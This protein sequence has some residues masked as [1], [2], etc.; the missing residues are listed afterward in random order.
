MSGVKEWFASWRLMSWRSALVA[1]F[2]LYTLVG[3]LVVPWVAEKVI[4]N[5]AH[6]KLGREVTV[7]KI[8]CNPFTLSLTVERLNL[9]DRPGS[10]MLSFDEMYANLQASSLFRWAFTLKEVRIENPYVA[11]RRFEDGGINVLEVK[12][13]LG[14]TMDFSDEA[15]GLPRA[16]LRE[17][18][19]NDAHFDIE[20]RAREEPLLWPGGPAQ[21]VL[22]EISTI[23]DGLGTNDIAIGL[24]AGGTIRIAGSVVV[25]PFGL[26]GA[27]SIDKIIAADLWP[28]IGHKFEFGVQGGEVATDLRYRIWLGE[29]GLGL[30]VD[31]LEAQVSDLSVSAPDS[32][33]DLVQAPAIVV[34]GGSLMWPEARLEAES[35]VVEGANAAVWL[36]PD[37]T[38]VWKTLVPEETRQELID[39]WERLNEEY[40]PVAT[41]QHF[42]VN[43]ATA[44]FEDR[45]FE[46]PVRVEASDAA[47]VVTDISS[48]PGSQ[49]GLEASAALAGG[50]PA[51]AIGTMMASPLTVDAEVGVEGLDLAQFQPYVGKFVPVELRAGQMTASGKARLAPS[52]EGP[53]VTFEGTAS[54]GDLDLVET[55]TD[56]SLL[57]WGE[58]KIDGIQAALLPTSAEVAK[59]DIHDA[60]LEVIVAEDGAINVLEFFNE[61]AP[62]LEKLP[63]AHIA[64]VELHDCF[65]RYFEEN[66]TRP[67]ELSLEAVNG[68]VVGFATNATTTSELE[69]DAAISTGGAVRVTGELDPL[70]YT[71]IT[72]MQVDVRD[73]H[74]PPMSPKSA[75]LVGHPVD[76]GTASLDLDIE[77]TD[78]Q[79]VS[80]N[81]VVITNLQLGERVDGDR[82][83]DLPV[84]LGVKLLK[85]KNGQI[86]LDIPV[87]G[88]MS[89]PD[90]VMTAAFT[91]AFKGLVGEIAKSPFRMLGRLAGGSD[92]QNLE[93]VDFA[94]GSTELESPVTTNLD[95][96]AKALAERPALVL[97]IAGTVD[98]E[99][100]A[101][102]LRKTALEDQLGSEGIDIAE[103]KTGELS[104][105]EKR[106]RN[107]APGSDVDSI[108]ARY[109]SGTEEP[110]LDE[111]AYRRALLDELIAAQAIDE[112]QVQSLAGA[113]AEAIRSY[114][115]D[116]AGVDTA[117]VE[118]RPEPVTVNEGED[119]VRCQLVLRD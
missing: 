104:S 26:E 90:F 89:N 41:L 2:I 50:A 113:R 63:P 79:L 27:L 72:D 40:S 6:D 23:P 116:T 95:T 106:V 11:L 65:G 31:G 53:D 74:L 115:V 46:E 35:V 64:Q 99:A 91:S 20:D 18:Y 105:L 8:R 66:P 37:G 55:V 110:T 69:V 34:S 117:R 45:T 77:I 60:G 82:V 119:P 44:V 33:S 109:T 36:E 14:N 38:P 107:T 86:T 83:I 3:F 57:K 67:F 32:D 22:S 78:Q 39:L 88:D 73:V 114:L 52:E 9:P 29:E 81:H 25:E 1:A 16:L 61:I 93:F 62:D 59:V 48:E 43:G 49:W 17:I 24:W 42:E 54:V 92:D 75:K 12:E 100:D 80:E 96:L 111:P 13:V 87:E 76:A 112:V 97:E 68:T 103:L 70:D 84:K 19:I 56:S 51:S 118:V 5:M 47:V 30:H 94:V 98:P 15:F 58:L 71:R 85:D 102:G 7:D 101:A 21:L 28:A 4:V 10:T 108:R